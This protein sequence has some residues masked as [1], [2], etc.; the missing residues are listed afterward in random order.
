MILDNLVT[1][2]QSKELSKIVKNDNYPVEID[3]VISKL[4]GLEEFMKE[5]GKQK[6]ELTLQLKD[7]FI[8][9]LTDFLDS[10]GD[11]IM[12]EPVRQNIKAE[13]NYK[14]TPEEQSKT[15]F[16]NVS[17]HIEEGHYF[18]LLILEKLIIENKDLSE[19]D[20]EF[21]EMA[22]KHF[23][24]Y[25]YIPQKIETDD[26]EGK[27]SA[28]SIWR[29]MPREFG[30]MDSFSV[31]LQWRRIYRLFNKVNTLNDK[32]NILLSAVYEL[33]QLNQQINETINAFERKVSSPQSNEDDK[34]K[35]V[36][37]TKLKT[38]FS[39]IFKVVIKNG[40]ENKKLYTILAKLFESA[41]GL[42]RIDIALELIHPDANFEG[43]IELLKSAPDGK[44]SIEPYQLLRNL[45]TEQYSLKERFNKLDFRTFSE[46]TLIEE[47][48]S[49][50]P[51]I[52]G[53]S[54][55]MVEATGNHTEIGTSA[56]AALRNL[57]KRHIDIEH[58]SGVVI[59]SDGLN[60]QGQATA[61]LMKEVEVN[62]VAIGSQDTLHHLELFN[63]QAPTRVSK[64]KK[65]TVNFNIRADESYRRDKFGRPGGKEVE[66]LLYRVRPDP[67]IPGHEIE[68]PLPFNVLTDV[69]PDLEEIKTVNL[70]N[71]TVK[72]MP[73]AATQDLLLDFE[74]EKG[75]HFEDFE[76]NTHYRLRINRRKYV[77]EDTFIDIDF[78]Q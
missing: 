48:S 76:I 2:E 58:L 63:L 50:T 38:E 52:F 5:P 24:K 13:I 47:L 12:T 71:K 53:D 22:R 68:V 61:E 26:T 30:L 23:A 14:S 4:R 29:K 73:V 19:F 11:D 28:N 40:L 20:K 1:V 32:K 51:E 3:K 77:D 35:L 31:A 67:D 27:D 74:P 49:E 34:A 9:L 8:E 25:K 60:N 44:K 65:V 56:D 10:L 37:I 59:I 54:L 45:R 66:V 57:L 70:K 21:S 43:M 15:F 46:G 6:K 33:Y 62:T 55:D 41:K 17:S 36:K 78:S 75:V 72:L 18:H 16:E 64:G 69:T 7:E 42:R 39:E